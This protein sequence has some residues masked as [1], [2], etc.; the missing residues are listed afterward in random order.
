MPTRAI[1]C[2]DCSR[3]FGIYIGV[4]SQNHNIHFYT[5]KIKNLELVLCD[6]IM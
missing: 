4:D 3:H 1:S 5:R 6:S 2:H